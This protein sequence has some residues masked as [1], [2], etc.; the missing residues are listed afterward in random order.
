MNDNPSKYIS[1]ALWF[2]RQSHPAFFRAMNEVFMDIRS[3]RSLK[4]HLLNKIL[5]YYTK[6]LRL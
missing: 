4:T 1:T 5:N 6:E 3:K 2:E